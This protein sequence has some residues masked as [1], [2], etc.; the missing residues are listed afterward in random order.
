MTEFY[1]AEMS[2]PSKDGCG[3]NKYPYYTNNAL[4]MVRTLIYDF[5]EKLENTGFRPMYKIYY[6]LDGRPFRIYMVDL[7]S[8]SYLDIMD[9]EV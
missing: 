5:K 3:V 8:E 1:K 4:N 6:I 7:L 9:L 2:I